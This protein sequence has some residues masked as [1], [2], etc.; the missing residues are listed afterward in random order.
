MTDAE[1]Q[2]VTDGQ[3]SVTARKARRV[4]RTLD[5]SVNKTVEFRSVV[6]TLPVL[7]TTKLRR[8][9]NDHGIS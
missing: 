2:A 5:Y 7:P 3:E 4:G 6:D 9:T 8:Y 1:E